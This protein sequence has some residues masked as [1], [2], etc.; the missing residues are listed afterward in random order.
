[1]AN[2]LSLSS[3][4]VDQCVKLRRSRKLKTPDAIIAATAMVY[5]LTLI[6]S[7]GVFSNISGLK[8]IDP[9]KY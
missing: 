6:T 2:V 1:D 5:G 3:E 8:V 7:D 4:V 9:R